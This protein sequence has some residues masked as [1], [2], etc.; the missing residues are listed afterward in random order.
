MGKEVPATIEEYIQTAP[1]EARPHLLLLNSILE[2]VAPEG[3][4]AIKWGVPV[5]GERRILFGFAAYKAHVSF[6]P[7]PDA[8]KHFSGELGKLR[9]GNSTIRFPYDQ[10]LPKE[11]IHRIAVY[12]ISGGGN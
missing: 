10:P 12:C 8:I 11:L 1:P 6:G 5:F 7:G 3:S 2:K 4:G 9:S